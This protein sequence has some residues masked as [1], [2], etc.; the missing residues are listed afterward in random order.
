[1]VAR[2]LVPDICYINKVRIFR[3]VKKRMSHKKAGCFLLC[4]KNKHYLCNRMFEI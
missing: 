3:N 1:M 2:G 4:L